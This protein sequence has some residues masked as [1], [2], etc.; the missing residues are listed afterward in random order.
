MTAT[1]TYTTGSKT[2]RVKSAKIAAG[3]LLLTDGLGHA[4]H[5]KTGAVVR[6]VASTTSALAGRSGYTQ[7]AQRRYSVTFTDGTV[8]TGYAPIYT[9][10]RV[11]E[12]AAPKAP[13][14][15]TAKAAH[16][17]GASLVAA[18][19]ASAEA[20]LAADKAAKAAA[21]QADLDYV[22]DAVERV[23]ATS[24]NRPVMAPNG[25]LSHAACD[26]DV[27]GR[28]ACRTAYRA[29]QPVAQAV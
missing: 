16:Q 1:T 21:L 26:H 17:F 2:D 20:S 3:D 10:H 11:T 23:Q 5:I 6:E 7:R 19:F 24:G 15:M 9:W 28:Y 29:A 14:A 22:A 8:V 13:K 4:A 27:T 25:K 18:V 12:V